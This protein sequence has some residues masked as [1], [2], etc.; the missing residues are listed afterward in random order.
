M[1]QIDVIFVEPEELY[2]NVWTGPSKDDG[3]I[4]NWDPDAIDWRERLLRKEE[5]E[6]TDEC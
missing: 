2:I 6:A 4:D 3:P 5:R 1:K